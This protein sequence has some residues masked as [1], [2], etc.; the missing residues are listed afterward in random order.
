MPSIQAIDEAR[1]AL[2]ADSDALVPSRMYWII[3]ASYG[4]F[5]RPLGR[6]PASRKQASL[7]D[8]QGVNALK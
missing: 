3:I 8:F 2:L 1:E 6:S 7:A 5:G 4:H